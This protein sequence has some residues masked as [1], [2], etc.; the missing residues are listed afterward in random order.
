MKEQVYEITVTDTERRIL[1]HALNYLRTRQIEEKKSYDFIDDLILR[2]CDAPIA[3][4][5][6]KRSY[7]ER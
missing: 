1:L 2:A 6:A 3:K 5:K 7:E 4:G